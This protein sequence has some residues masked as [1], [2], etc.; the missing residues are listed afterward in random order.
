MTH[1][2]PD[3]QR[4]AVFPGSFNPFTL[5]HLSVA[6]RGARLFDRLIIAIG[7]NAAKPLPPETIERRLSAIRKAVARFTNVEVDSY[8][9][10]TVDYAKAR[11]AAF[12]LRGARSVADFEYERQIAD[13]N[14]QVAGIETVVLF[15]LPEY[16]SVSSSIVRELQSYGYDISRF[17]P[18]DSE[19]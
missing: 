2:S 13:V 16:A 18:T 17:I 11:G 8:T 5:G 9:G 19:Q 7:V 14:R 6:E 4:T 12:I 1:R 15:T 3:P 10:L